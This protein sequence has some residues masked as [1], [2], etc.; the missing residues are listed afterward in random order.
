MQSKPYERVED[1]EPKTEDKEVVQEKVR[2]MEE[3]GC[4]RYVKLVFDDDIRY[5]QLPINCSV[6]LM[7]EIVHD[8][9]P[10]LKGALVKYM[11]KDGDLVTITTTNE[12]RKAEGLSD[13]HGSLRLYIS[14][15]SPDQEPS[16]DKND[17]DEVSMVKRKLYDDTKNDSTCIDSWIIQFAHLFKTHVGFETDSYLDLHEVGMKLY[18]EAIEDTVVSEDAQELF[19]IASDKFQEMVALAL[20]NM[21]N[22]HMSKARKHASISEDTSDES[23]ILQIKSA[24]KWAKK[25]YKGRNEI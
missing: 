19:D 21:R 8:R 15:V 2:V 1:E 5:A 12:L 13:L 3:K 17:G 22:V 24:Y 20:L 7:N 18:S 4:L 25:E 6:L 11:D 10:N 14:E 16:Y 9:F 23:L